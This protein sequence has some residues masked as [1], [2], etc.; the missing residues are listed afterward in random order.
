MTDRKIEGPDNQRSMR[1]DAPEKVGK[2][3]VWI[4]VSS[5]EP[6]EQWFGTEILDHST[7]S[8]NLDF[9]G[10]GS[11]P[12]LMDHDPRRQIGVVEEA[13]LDVE[14]RRLR[15]KVRFSKN[16]DASEV[17]DDVMD[18]IRT[19]VSVGYSI[20]KTERDEKTEVVTVREWSPM[21]VSIVSIPAD[22]TVGVGRS[23]PDQK[24][25]P[26]PGKVNKMPDVD[27]E[28]VRADAI[29]EAER[30]HADDI[31][32]RDAAA[33]TALE[34][35]RLEAGEIFA[36]GARHNMTDKA[37]EFAKDGKSL[38][39]FR[40]HVLENLPNGKPLEDTDIGLSGREADEFSIM[41]LTRAAFGGRGEREAAAFELEACQAAADKLG[42]E[43]KTRGFRVPTDVMANWSQRDLAAGTDTQLIP[44]EHR[45]GSFIDALRNASSVMAAGATTLNGL[46]GNVDI[47]AKNAVSTATWISS[48]GTDSTE[49]EPTFRTVSLT[50]NDVSLYT[51]MTRRMQQQS[52]PDIEALVRSDITAA[53][54]LA[55][56]AAGLEG[57]GSGGTPEGILN[58][59]GIGK[60]TAF[61]AANPTYAEVIA[62]E[63]AV[64]DDNAL[65]GNLAYIGTTSMWGAMKSTV[66]D[67][68]SGNFV[69]NVDG[70][71]NGYRYIK[72]NQGTAGNLYFGNWSDLLI[73]MWGGLDLVVDDAALALSGGRRLIVFQTV[74][75]AVRHAESFAYNNDT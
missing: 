25:E 23:K 62:L 64:A 44:T 61:A 69:A 58:V 70:T 2:R 52:S 19:N 35:A 48:E 7:R 49:S 65:M 46:S 12:L 15:A 72:S 71:T 75:M 16:S 20:E 53:I 31:S 9:F 43:V 17:F 50:P 21:E 67:A 68:G 30:N 1:M 34:A 18:N 22:K 57:S 5:E 38:S 59:T 11:A 73:G 3:E 13:S 29:A 56:D 8:V 36:L 33:A 74:D 26:N 27:V 66:V 39:E 60:P 24:H 4:S 28:K 37:A 40:G 32:Q 14:T 42:S 51:D 45:A 10:G 41:R 54:A 63:T 55:V 6:A 47:P